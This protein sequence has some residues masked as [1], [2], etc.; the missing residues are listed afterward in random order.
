MEHGAW[1]MELGAWSLELGA[2][3][4]EHGAWGMEH[5]AWSMACK[6]DWF[7]AKTFVL[8]ESNAFNPR[9]RIYFFLLF[10]LRI[11]LIFLVY[12]NSKK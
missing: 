9:S 7:H 3:S 2:W 8:T 12:Q 5:G 4:M 1:S 11:I 6:V 10:L